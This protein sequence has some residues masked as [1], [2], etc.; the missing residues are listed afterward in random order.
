MC[1]VG[2]FLCLP[3]T[4]K[5]SR[6][7]P[8]HCIIWCSFP[9]PF[10]LLG[11][12]RKCRQEH[13]ASPFEFDG[14]FDRIVVASLKPFSRPPFHL[15]LPVEPL[16]QLTRGRA[17]RILAPVIPGSF[18]DAV[19]NLRRSQV[20]RPI[21]GMF[22]ALYAVFSFIWFRFMHLRVQSACLARLYSSPG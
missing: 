4:M 20:P 17:R 3:S 12:V 18:L 11:E 13:A 14:S 15:R 5:I 1:F 19:W 10:V 9:P 8:I 16:P 7:L 21:R 2:C 6:N 22:L